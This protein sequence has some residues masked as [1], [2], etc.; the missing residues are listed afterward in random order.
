MAESRFLPTALVVMGVSGCGKSTV[1]ELLGRHFD[2]PFRDGDS[3]HSA[4]NVAKMHAGIPL[5]DEDR[6]PWLASIAAWIAELRGQ[7]KHGI[8]ACSALKR[9]YRN[10]L[11]DGHNDVRF[12]FLEGSMELIAARLA[13]RKNHYMPSSL[14]ASQ[15]ATLEPLGADENPITVS[16]DQEP[17]EI[18]GDALRKLIQ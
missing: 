9:V 17:E 18:A 8:I 14:L 10:A 15:F 13:K 4:A 3:F 5:T 11:R 12:V 1:G 6:W 16:I 7:G 2:W